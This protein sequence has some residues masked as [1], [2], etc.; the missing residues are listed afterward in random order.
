MGCST[1]CRNSERVYLSLARNA[2]GPSAKNVW[3]IVNAVDSGTTWRRNC[4]CHPRLAHVRATTL[5]QWAGVAYSWMNIPA[6]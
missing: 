1:S 6:E 3:R 4:G 2:S 5:S